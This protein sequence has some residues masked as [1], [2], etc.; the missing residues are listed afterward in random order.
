MPRTAITPHTNAF[1]TY[2]NSY[3]QCGG[4][5][6][7]N[8]TRVLTFCATCNVRFLQAGDVGIPGFGTIRT[9]PEEL[10]LR[11]M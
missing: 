5:W 7:F 4:T 1:V 9:Y 10:R 2:L 6:A 11:C 8:V 3:C